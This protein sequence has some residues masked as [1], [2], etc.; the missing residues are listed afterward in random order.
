MDRPDV[1]STN[2]KIVASIMDVQVMR[3]AIEHHIN[4]QVAQDKVLE[5]QQN[6]ELFSMLLGE[7]Y[8]TP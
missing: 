7:D 6:V 1:F 2:A 5:S 3:Y 8:F 4:W